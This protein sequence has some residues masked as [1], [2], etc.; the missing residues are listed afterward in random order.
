MYRNVHYKSDHREFQ[1]DINSILNW[2]ET[3]GMRLNIGK[4]HHLKFTTKTNSLNFTYKIATLS[5]NAEQHVEY[6]GVYF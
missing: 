4:C 1:A 3:W 5:V 6:L 2:C